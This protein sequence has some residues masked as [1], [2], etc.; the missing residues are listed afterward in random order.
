MEPKL[1][2]T[3]AKWLAEM[4]DRARY[5]NGNTL[6]RL[7]DAAGGNRLSVRD[8]NDAQAFSVDSAG[9][10]T[11]WP[12]IPFVMDEAPYFA[13]LENS[14]VNYG[15]DFQTA[16]F[17]RTFAGTTL[18]AGLIKDGTLGAAML[19]LPVGFRPEYSSLYPSIANDALGRV[20]VTPAG[21]V[22]H[23]TGSNAWLSL[24]GIE[25]VSSAQP[26]V[27]PTLTGSWVNYGV[28][29]S[30]AGY[31]KDRTG[32]VRLRGL[33]R[34]GSNY[35]SLAMTLPEGCRPPAQEIF[36]TTSAGYIA[37]LSVQAD[38]GVHF[39]G[40]VAGDWSTLEPVRF[41]T[42]TQGWVRPTLVN[43]WSDF[44]GSFAPAA[45]T[46]DQF[47]VVRLR[48][49]IAGGTLSSSFPAF[50]LPEGYRPSKYLHFLSIANDAF[51][52]IR[53]NAQGEVMCNAASNAWFS[54]SGVAFRTG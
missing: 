37:R 12:G 13:T 22:Q 44:G 5:V 31:V 45:Y 38:G 26:W 24:S 21:A 4:V 35:P 49:V 42:R 47:G 40:S 9:F 1:L 29:W 43:G 28:G 27:A 6:L 14:W 39:V 10:A 30:P 18:L 23:A 7:G 33:I 16:S 17:H 34:N 52:G 36:A 50:T 2:G 46:R 8:S 3:W 32:I 54:L 11:R 19:T 53:V 51:A 48:G 20:D 15:G 41:D 25:S